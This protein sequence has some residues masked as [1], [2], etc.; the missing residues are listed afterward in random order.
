MEFSIFLSDKTATF[1]AEG[2]YDHSIENYKLFVDDGVLD[3]DFLR[4]IINSKKLFIEYFNLSIRKD[5]NYLEEK[6]IENESNKASEDLSPSEKN[7]SLI[8]NSFAMFKNYLDAKKEKF[9]IID[10]FNKN[11]QNI[12]ALNKNKNNNN[13]SVEK[14]EYG[15]IKTLSIDNFFREKIKERFDFKKLTNKDN[16]WG[17][18]DQRNQFNQK[19]Q[20]IADFCNEKDCYSD[21]YKKQIKEI[22]IEIH[23]IEYLMNNLQELNYIFLSINDEEEKKQA[24]DE[25]KLGYF[26]S[27]ESSKNQVLNQLSEIMIFLNDQIKVLL[28]EKNENIFKDNLDSSERLK[29][30]QERNK[31]LINLFSEN[32]D[33]KNFI[34]QNTDDKT[35]FQ[36]NN[37]IKEKIDNI[38]KI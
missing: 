35:G 36:F 17:T 4:P 29:I 25:C 16:E 24:I 30:N 31:H 10:F 11:L 3:Y 19:F 2:K 23:F 1:S 9:N 7:L 18:K 26:F 5:T 15:N 21:E 33:Y 8:K 13:F 28:D 34:Q 37:A 6:Y 14:D 20:D 32:K 22:Y 38:G 27:D 12:S